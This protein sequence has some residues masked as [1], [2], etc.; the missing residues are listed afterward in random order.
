MINK[1]FDF[2]NLHTGEEQKEKVLE[3]IKSNISFRGSN[4]W[5][6]ACAIVI[7]S[8]GLNVNSTAV[9]IGAMLI[10]PLMGPIVGAGFALAIYDFELLKKSGKN[11]LIATIV[12]L[13]V[14]T[15]YFYLSPFKVAQSELCLLYTSRCV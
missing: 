14:A 7:A 11:L 12:S 4:L 13:I 6:L 9:I 3:N 5:I 8:V 10:S 1:F 2:I 15:L